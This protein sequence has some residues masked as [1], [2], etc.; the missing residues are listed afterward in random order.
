MAGDVR[1]HALLRDRRLAPAV[2]GFLA[3]SLAIAQGPAPAAAPVF[4]TSDQCIACHS[5]LTDADGQ[6][7]SIGHA[8]RATMMANSARDPY[9]QAAVRREVMDQPGLQAAIEDTCSTCHMPMA[10]TAA[11]AAGGLGEVFAHLGPDAAAGPDVAAALDGVSC[12]V[13][14]QIRPDNLGEHESFDGGF[15]VGG[16]EAGVATAFGPFDDVDEGLQ[17]IMESASG[18]QPAAGAHIQESELCATCHTLFTTARDEEGR[19]VGRLPEQVPYLEWLKSG[20]RGDQSCQDCHMP[21]AAEAPI[22]S[23]LGEQREGLSL[24]A[25]RG[26]NVF[27]LRL[28]N[29]YRDELNVTAPADELEASAARTAEHLRNDTAKIDRLELRLGSGEVVVDVEVRNLAGHKLP[30]AY[31]SRRAWL[32]LTLRDQDGAV[33]FE[34]GAMRPDG[35]IAG[36]DN[37]ADP[38]AFEPHHAELSAPDQVQIYESI[39]VD[40]ADRVTTALLRGVR[41]AKDNRLLPEGFDKASAPG[42]VAVLGAAVSDPD[43]QAGVDTVRYRVPVATGVTAVTASAR[44]L[45]QTIGY[46]WAR[47]LGEYDAF[48]TNRFVGYYEAN[49]AESAVLLAAAEAEARMIRTEA[50][51]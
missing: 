8:W 15:V 30:T 38:G 40:H 17:R 18:F 29:R 48:E 26:G 27:M 31:P 32:H 4:E 6:D 2:V 22:S 13:C 24:H 28:L 39:I 49:A 47:N 34:S 25:F 16:P 35:S 42:D 9:W 14:H 20:Y 37:D 3:T 21:V 10:R 46:R 19:E 12:T 23:V 36:N 44:L 7:V 45:F 11:K 41:Y 51:K 43:F 33:L 50:R 1:F 5:N